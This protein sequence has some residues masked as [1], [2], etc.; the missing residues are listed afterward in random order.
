LGLSP[1]ASWEDVEAAYKKLLRKNHPDRFRTKEAKDKAETRFKA[2][3]VAYDALKAG[4]G[5]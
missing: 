5:K 3:R 2:V 4:L 1:G